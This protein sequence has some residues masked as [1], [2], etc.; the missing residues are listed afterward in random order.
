MRREEMI[1][2][3]QDVRNAIALGPVDQAAIAEVKL[4]F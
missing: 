4:L 3:A 2:L 1:N